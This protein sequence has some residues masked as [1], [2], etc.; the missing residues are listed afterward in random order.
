MEIKN[1]DQEEDHHHHGLEISHEVAIRKVLSDSVKF[2]KKRGVFERT[3]Q[4]SNGRQHLYEMKNGTGRLSDLK[5]AAQLKDACLH[6]LYKNK[7]IR[8]DILDEFGRDMTPKQA[9]KEFNIKF[10]GKRPGF[11]RKVKRLQH[12]HRELKMK[13]MMSSEGLPSTRNMKVTIHE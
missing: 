11:N 5:S 4:H 2:L 6:R 9:F 13:R 8:I 1:L 10:H 12:Y 3:T 7:E